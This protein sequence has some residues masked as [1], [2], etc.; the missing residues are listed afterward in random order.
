MDSKKL[1]FIDRFQIFCLFAF[2]CFDFF[3][4]S[5]THIFGFLGGGLW[6]LKTHLTRTWDKVRFPLLVPF[7]LYWGASLVSVATSL[8]PIRSFPHLKR[9]FEVMVFFWALN[10]LSHSHPAD[11]F[12]SLI[13]TIRNS[14]FGIFLSQRIE[15]SEST[16]FKDIFLCWLF[17]A[18]SG[19]A[20]LGLVQ[21]LINGVN[22][23]SRVS[24]TLSI[25]ITFA[26][27]LMQV[28]LVI[29][30]Y[31]CFRKND[32]KW[33]WGA[34][35]LVLTCLLLTLTRGS[36]GAFIVGTLFLLTV[37]QPK[38]LFIL[39]FL[40]I[41]LYFISPQ[42]VQNRLKS[43]SDFQDITLQ[44]RLKMW[45]LGW[46]VFQD[47][48]VTGC[49]FNCLK[50]VRSDYPEHDWFFN[51]HSHVHNNLLQ[52]AVDTG[53]LGVVT[54]LSI[55]V[56]YFWKTYQRYRENAGNKEHRWTILGSAAAVLGF[57]SAGAFECNF[58]DS[59]IVLM[60]YILMALPWVHSGNKAPDLANSYKPV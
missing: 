9:L 52:V 43:L 18:A 42:P 8:D 12:R 58:Y 44:N 53:I 39:P 19:A 17:I 46:T 4:I 5:L 24:G 49:G 16:S 55:W 47:Y 14:R 59:E 30:A 20:L 54:W 26:G 2:I 35:A 56:C 29:A 36:W 60:C 57:L 48:P 10:T 32:N 34:L 41:A 7:L 1:N 6:L 51:K 13:S 27:L 37:R 28:G 23:S 11:L 38:I 22:L 45:Q 25:Y 21:G 50:M 15:Q 33:T 40:M 31:I 3:S